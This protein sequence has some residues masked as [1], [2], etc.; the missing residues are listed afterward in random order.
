[1]VAILKIERPSGT[2]YKVVIKSPGKYLKSKCFTRMTDAT[3]WAKRIEGDQ[4][5][6][7]SLRSAGSVMSFS[8]LADEYIAQ[9]QGVSPNQATRLAYWVE[10]FGSHRLN[11][12]TPELIRHR[13]KVLI[14][15]PIKMR[16]ARG[17][18]KVMD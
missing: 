3:N 7:E 11:A 16:M 18:I 17:K 6:V 1:M 13:M 8:E 15:E 12:I 14:A 10:A 4:E 2:V 9:W 5:L